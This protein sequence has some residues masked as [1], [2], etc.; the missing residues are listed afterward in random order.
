MQEDLQVNTTTLPNQPIFEKRNIKVNFASLNK[1]IILEIVTGQRYLK[2]NSLQ[3]H[4]KLD[5]QNQPEEEKHEKMCQVIAE[6]SNLTP[7]EAFECLAP[8]EVMYMYLSI[9]GDL[10]ATGELTRLTRQK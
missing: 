10:E 1:E 2:F 5:S 8:L 6:F 7:E 4:L 3:K 9:Q